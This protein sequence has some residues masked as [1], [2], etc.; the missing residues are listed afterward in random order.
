[1][2]T[3]RVRQKTSTRAPVARWFYTWIQVCVVAFERRAH[4]SQEHWRPDGR[5]VCGGREP[6]A[7]PHPRAIG[8][9]RGESPAGPDARALRGERGEPI[10]RPH[11]GPFR[12]HHSVPAGR[13]NR[14]ECVRGGASMTYLDCT[15]CGLS[16]LSRDPLTDRVHCPR[17][18]ARGCARP[19]VRSS[20]PRRELSAAHSGAGAAP[21]VAR[22]IVGNP[23]WGSR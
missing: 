1:L 20:L 23:P 22:A 19:L 4:E 3:L 6:A 9:K 21:A 5:R 12:R 8:W 14:P 15:H 2:R 16:V 17:C 13:P 7:R 11:P 10:A 18:Q